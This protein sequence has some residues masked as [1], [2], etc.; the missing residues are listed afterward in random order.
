MFL[1]LCGFLLQVKGESAFCPLTFR[2]GSAMRTLLLHLLVH[3]EAVFV[4]LVG[5]SA[6]RLLIFL[7][8]FSYWMA[9]YLQ[10]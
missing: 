7:Y 9:R 2:G 10:T 5:F 1:I 4:L 6:S 8:R 3:K